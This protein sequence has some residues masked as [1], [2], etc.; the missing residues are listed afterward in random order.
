MSLLGLPRQWLRS[1]ALLLPPRAS[2][3]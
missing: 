3:R 2:F 1:C